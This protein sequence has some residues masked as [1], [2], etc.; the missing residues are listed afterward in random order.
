MPRIVFSIT[1]TPK[2][3][4]HKKKAP[5]GA[6][7]KGAPQA[8]PKKGA[9]K[10]IPNVTPGKNTHNS[11]TNTVHKGPKERCS[12]C[13]PH[14]PPS[15]YVND[16]VRGGTGM[17]KLLIGGTATAMQMIGTFGDS[18]RSMQND[19]QQEHRPSTKASAKASSSPRKTK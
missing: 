16:I 5:K 12:K 7:K 1:R 3:D 13:Y 10:A 15:P 8:T 14:H 11:F 18:L 17:V 19:T 2:N 4:P 9:P 6:P